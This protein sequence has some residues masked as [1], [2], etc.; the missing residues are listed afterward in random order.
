MSKIKKHF[1]PPK[2]YAPTLPVI[3]EELKPDD[4]Y[5]LIQTLDNFGDD[6]WV[7]MGQLFFEPK[8]EE[9]EN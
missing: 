7:V 3:F 2:K 4:Q 8:S 9:A 6:F 5:H 1:P